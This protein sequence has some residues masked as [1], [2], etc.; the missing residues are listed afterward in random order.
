MTEPKSYKASQT[1][2]RVTLPAC[3]KAREGTRSAFPQQTHSNG[4]DNGVN[5]HRDLHHL[6]GGGAEMLVSTSS[7]AKTA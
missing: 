2:R 1:M 5:Q 6:L 7:I 3:N 4:P